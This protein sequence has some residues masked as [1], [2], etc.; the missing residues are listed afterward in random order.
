MR[1]SL[2]LLLALA[3][4]AQA[5]SFTEDVMRVP[6]VSGVEQAYIEVT[7]FRPEGAGPFPVLVLSHGSPRSAAARRAG[8]R[9]RMAAQSERFVAMGFAVLVPTRRGYGGSGGEWAEA[10]G[11]CN[12]PD[13]YTAGMETA[14]D[15]RAAVDAVR[16]EPWADTG[17]VVLA[18]QSAGGFGSVAA[19]SGPFAGLLGVVNFAGGRGSLAP[20]QVCGEDQLIEAMARF[21]GGARVP[22]LWIYSRNDQFFGPGLARRMH[23]A[24][25][26]SGGSAEFVEAPAVGLDGHGYFARAMDD[27]APRVEGFLARI[28]AKGR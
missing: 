24:F 22:E 9:Q 12:A 25:T 23:A 16:G 17:R 10:Y 18:G 13:Y 8:G 6:V 5:A 15:L 11:R 14:R 7:V 4:P 1:A 20:G 19:A 3:L 28:G 26:G 2:A 21:G 27:W